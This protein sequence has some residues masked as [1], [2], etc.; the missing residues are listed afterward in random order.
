MNL[1]FQTTSYVFEKA[2][3]LLCKSFVLKQ[4]HPSITHYTVSVNNFESIYDVFSLNIYS[5]M[6]LNRNFDDINICF[7][8]V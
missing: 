8:Y 5:L 6:L 3:K 2:F 7:V 4:V 1:E